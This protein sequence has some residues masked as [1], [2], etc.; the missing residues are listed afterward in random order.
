MAET[1]LPPNVVAE[2]GVF[3]AKLARSAKV[4]IDASTPTEGRIAM[5]EVSTILRD[6]EKKYETIAE[7]LPL[8]SNTSDL[9]DNEV[10]PVCYKLAASFAQQ[11]EALS[12]EVKRQGNLHAQA[13]KKWWQFWR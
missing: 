2:I 3:S 4:L 13:A 8:L 6:Y 11:G 7:L 9:S 1:P 12:E 10:V 5:S